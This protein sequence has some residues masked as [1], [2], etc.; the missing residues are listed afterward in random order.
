MCLPCFSW[1]E[2]ALGYRILIACLC[3]THS[4]HQN[5]FNLC[6]KDYMV[7]VL[8]SLILRLFLSSFFGLKEYAE[9][10]QRTIR[11]K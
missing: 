6:Y 5:E 1:G 4:Q 3:S 9:N 10:L 8:R 7:V 11:R 2:G